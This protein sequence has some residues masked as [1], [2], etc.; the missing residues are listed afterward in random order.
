MENFTLDKEEIAIE[1]DYRDFLAAKWKRIVN[2]MIDYYLIT[3]IWLIFIFYVDQLVEDGDLS[4]S[5]EG[6]TSLFLIP[7]ILVPLLYLF[8]ERYT[9]KTLGKLITGTKVISLT[10]EPITMK[11]VIFRTLS[12]LVPFEPISLILAN[13]AWHDDWSDTAVV[14]NS[15][16]SNFE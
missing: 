10:G 2:F 9:G 7:F 16:K 12:R 5:D 8:C 3:F 15:Y 4:I 11:Q 6:Y 13:T 14:D 1:N